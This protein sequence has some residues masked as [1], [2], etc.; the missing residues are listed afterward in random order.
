MRQ[1]LLILLLIAPFQAHAA[2]IKSYDFDGDLTDTLGN[3][4][5]LISGGGTLGGG[6]YTFGA[7]QGLRLDS[8]LANTSDY[9]IEIKFEFDSI[10][11]FWKKVLDYQNLA[12]DTGLYVAVDRVRFYDSTAGGPT[13]I[14]TNTDVVARITRDGAT[15]QVQGFIDN[16]LQWSFNDAGNSAVPG[17]NIL[18]FFED[19]TATGKSETL[20]GS[21]DW[22]RIYDNTPVPVPEP[23]TLALLGA[24]LLGLVVRRKRVA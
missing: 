21:V 16:I 1:L 2:L 19:D 12:T 13:P 7:N 10:D 22:I 20:V 5:D 9:A 11:P 15:N 14:P 6:R 4:L 8:A 24:G 18:N 23:S 17:G 3:G